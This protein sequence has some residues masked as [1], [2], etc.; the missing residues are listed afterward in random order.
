MAGVIPGA[1]TLVGLDGEWLEPYVTGLAVDTSDEQ[2]AMRPDT[3]F[4]LAS[5]TK[6]VA[7]LPA[8][9]LLAQDGVADLQSPLVNVFDEWQSDPS[10]ADITAMHLL[11]HT[12]GLP[13][14]CDLHSHGWSRRRIVEEVLGTPL[15][16]PPGEA[17]VY[18]D[19]GFILLGEWLERLAGKTLDRWL[20][21]RVYG[22]LRMQDTG[23]LPGEELRPRLAACE[24][25][26]QLGRH[27]LGEVNDDNAQ[28]MGGVSGH[29]G[30]FSTAGDLARYLDACWLPAA[31]DRPQLLAPVAARAALRD[32][33]AHLGAH[34]GLGWALKNDPWDSSGLLSSARTFGHTGYT[35]TSL[36]VDPELGLGIILLTNRVHKSLGPGIVTLRRRF[37]NVVIAAVVEDGGTGRT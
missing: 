7:T 5:L 20:A 14:W 13:A 15:E 23:F 10:K 3:V 17:C 32:R 8:A 4:D 31:T 30:L 1:V 34:R 29:A 6:V 21:D 16:A 19:L 36:V 22:P 37:H 9:L 12:S 2:R 18:S 26:E 33:T 27:Q 24:Y 11:T 28:A 35:G 25:R